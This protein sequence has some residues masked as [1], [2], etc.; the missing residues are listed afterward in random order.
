LSLF[1]QEEQMKNKIS[2]AKP[3]AILMVGVAGLMG[4]ISPAGK[5]VYAQYYCTLTCGA[6]VP[7]T[8]KA[9]SAV[10]FS[11]SANASYCIGSPEY[12]WDFGDG[13]NAAASNASHT[14]SK[15]GTYT[16]TVSV[17]VD[18]AS[19][20]R[21]GTIIISADIS[22][23]SGVSAASY[24]GAAL[25]SE[26]IVAAFGSNLA[27]ATQVATSV[28][29]P[30]ALAGTTVK[31]KDSTGNERLAPL[32]FVSPGQINHQIPPGTANG[33]ATVTVT[34]GNTTV[35]TGTALI[36]SVAPGLFSANSSGQG[37][38]SGYILR[39]KADNSQSIEAINQFDSAQS[40]FVSVPID[41]GPATDQ[42]FLILFGTGIRFRSSLAGV[43]AKIGGT[44]VPVSF[45]GPQGDFVGLDQ[46]NMQ[47]PRSLLGRGELDL[48]LTVD[49][50]T[51]N[52]VKVTIK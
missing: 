12:S 36:A 5:A 16:W 30:T 42:V 23:V 28:P 35:A 3:L 44:D 9:G 7:A 41:L 38:A 49:S 8:A 24:D 39:V 46:L 51:A 13:G 2:Y 22:T 45:A 33:T 17:V 20:S 15:A 47:L 40:K 37:V 48:V 31:V 14:Y 21:S 26:A 18:D 11:A 4:W 50:K 10:A 6:S 43:S 1:A 34:S 25:T 32:F 19:A 29:L 52:T 27:T